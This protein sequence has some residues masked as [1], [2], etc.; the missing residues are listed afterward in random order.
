MNGHRSQNERIELDVDWLKN[1]LR[2]LTKQQRHT[3]LLEYIDAVQDYR[4]GMK[5][6]KSFIE[7]FNNLEG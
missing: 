7:V 5:E 2:H 3:I 4:I 1:E 6:Y